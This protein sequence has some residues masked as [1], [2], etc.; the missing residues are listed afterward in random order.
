[1]T[2][3]AVEVIEA[4]RHRLMHYVREG[5]KLTMVAQ[6]MKF[7]VMHIFAWLTGVPVDNTLASTFFGAIVGSDALKSFGK[8]SSIASQ[9][10]PIVCRRGGELDGF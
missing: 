4:N 5:A 1:M 8:R 3:Q 9:K 7:G 10:V 6:T 2:R